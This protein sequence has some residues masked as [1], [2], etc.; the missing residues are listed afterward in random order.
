MDNI[1]FLSV[2]ALSYYALSSVSSNK[3]QTGFIIDNKEDENIFMED[4]E[5]L[6]ND[7]IN[8]YLKKTKK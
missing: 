2:G 1:A 8:E 5:I 6:T 7:K 4:A 3:K